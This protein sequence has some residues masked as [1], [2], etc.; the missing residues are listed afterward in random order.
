MTAV[1]KKGMWDESVASRGSCKEALGACIVCLGRAQ[2]DV[3]FD[4]A[5]STAEFNHKFK[6]TNREEAS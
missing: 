3:N 1:R 4:I 6:T 2:R 5:L